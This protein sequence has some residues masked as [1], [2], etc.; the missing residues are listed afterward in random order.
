[1]SARRI[2]AIVV[3]TLL[4]LLL[5]TPVHSRCFVLHNVKSRG[6]DVLY[7]HCLEA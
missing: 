4:F 2:D 1:M 3:F 7:S 6:K 5:P